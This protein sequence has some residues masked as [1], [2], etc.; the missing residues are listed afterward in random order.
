[1]DDRSCT[2]TS[3]SVEIGWQSLTS[4][5]AVVILTASSLGAGLSQSLNQLIAFRAL[6]GV[7]G[8]GIYSLPFTVLPEITPVAKF[9]LMSAVVG[10][11][12][13]CSA[14]LGP[15][16]GGVIT[17]QSTWRWIFLLNV[18]CGLLV[19]ALILIAWPRTRAVGKISW[20]QLDLIGCLLCVAASVLLVFALQQAGAGAYA[21]SSPVIIASL[22]VAAA[23]AIALWFWIW[24]LSSADRGIAPLFPA[25]VVLNR[26]IVVAI[27]VSTLTGY[28]LY[29]VIIELPERLQ[30]VSGKTPQSAGIALL[31]L[32]GASAVSSGIGGY[33]SSGRGNRSFCTLTGA[34]AFTLLGSASIPPSLYGYEVLLG[35]GLGGALVSTIVTVKLSAR[36]EDAGTP[37]SFPPLSPPSFP[38]PPTLTQPPASAQGLLSQSRLLGGNIGLALA[39]FILSAHLTADLAD[40]L[41]PQQISAL[42]ASLNALQSFTPVEVAAVA[43]SFARASRTQLLAC[44]GVAAAGLLLGVVRGREGRRRGRMCR[45]GEGRAGERGRWGRARDCGGGMG[46]GSLGR[47]A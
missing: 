47:E 19:V 45:E 24:Y 28:I 29:S 22:T 21:S 36:L 10:T 23:A 14:V 34:S 33:L 13:L 46:S 43:A 20:R 18:P 30:I 2:A 7:G 12:F 3:A 6:Q 25:R 8:S 4:L 31:P 37:L 44:V 9:P 5:Q 16:L 40:I 15:T 41:T 11:T 39:T 38:T 26:V 17:T 1:M 42:L 27:T 32:L 35:L